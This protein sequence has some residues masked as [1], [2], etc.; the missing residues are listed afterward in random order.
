MKSKKD[1]FYYCVRFKKLSLKHEEKSTGYQQNPASSCLLVIILK[2]PHLF[3]FR[4]SFHCSMVL[5]LEFF[6][7]KYAF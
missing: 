4:T 6:N 7:D 2:L 1:N 5:S 3:S